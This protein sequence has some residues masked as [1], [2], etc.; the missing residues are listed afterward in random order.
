[1]THHR[2]AFGRLVNCYFLFFFLALPFLIE[3]A[4]YPTNLHQ[5]IERKG[6]ELGR[7]A[8]VFSSSFSFFSL[9]S[10]S[11]HDDHDESTYSL[12]FERLEF[13]FSVVDHI[14]RVPKGLEFRRFSSPYWVADQS[15]AVLGEET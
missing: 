6:R 4:K 2:R 3:S 15:G 5:S 1:M 11:R 9:T 13:F 12:S 7:A 14:G 10:F 8:I